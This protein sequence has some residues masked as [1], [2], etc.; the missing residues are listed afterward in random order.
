M[1]SE[2]DLCYVSDDY[3]EYYNEEEEEVTN[4]NG[5]DDN[6][7]DYGCEEDEGSYDYSAEDDELVDTTWNCTVWSED[8]IHRRQEEDITEICNG[9]LVSRVSTTI[10]LYHYKWNV[11]KVLDDWFTNEENVRMTIGLLE[12]PVFGYPDAMKLICA[13]CFDKFR[14]RNMY[15]ASCGHIFV[16]HAGKDIFLQIDELFFKK[17]CCFSEKRDED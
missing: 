8:D 1:D 10:L 11:T 13:I 14:R 3:D 16:A 2:D 6:Y 12:K 15:T 4:M 7:D 5:E 17:F 9:L